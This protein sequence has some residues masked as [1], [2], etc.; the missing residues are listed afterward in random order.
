MSVSHFITFTFNYTIQNPTK[1]SS[2]DTSPKKILANQQ[3]LVGF[4]DAITLAAVIGNEFKSIEQSI[5]NAMYYTLKSKGI[6]PS[7]HKFDSWDYSKNY[8]VSKVTTNMASVYHFVIEQSDCNPYDEE[9]YSKVALLIA[10][11]YELNANKEQLLDSFET[12]LDML[13]SQPNTFVFPAGKYALGDLS[14]YFEDKENATYSKFWNTCEDEILKPD[15]LEDGRWIGKMFTFPTTPQIKMAIFPTSHHKMEIKTRSGV[16]QIE[17]R[18]FTCIAESEFLSFSQWANTYTLEYFQD[19]FFIRYTPSTK[20]LEFK[21]LKNVLNNQISGVTS[22]L[23]ISLQNEERPTT[24]SKIDS[25]APAP[26]KGPPLQKPCV[27]SVKSKS[28]KEI[29]KEVKIDIGKNKSKTF[30]DEDDF[31][32]KEETVMDTFDSDMVE[33]ED[34]KVEV[35]APKKLLPM[36]P[37]SHEK[38]KASFFKETLDKTKSSVLPTPKKQKRAAPVCEDEVT[39]DSYLEDLEEAAVDERILK[40]SGLVKH[41][42]IQ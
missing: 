1:R 15:N 33:V 34:E 40:E 25:N 22:L 18:T 26:K 11:P 42:M 16:A 36:K 24:I 14:K 3:I 13:E 4:R 30:H 5:R 29:T 20:T 35:E 38:E 19:D 23:T 41:A 17:G 32:E 7:S 37:I 27:S 21:T 39:E 31:Y 12:K 10:P 2:W 28:S 8:K 6:N 9:R